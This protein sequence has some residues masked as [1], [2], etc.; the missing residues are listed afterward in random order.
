VSGATRKK[1]AHG[2]NTV[3]PVLIEFAIAGGEVYLLQS[4][5]VTTL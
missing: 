4:R 1:G 3:S 2:G 5:P